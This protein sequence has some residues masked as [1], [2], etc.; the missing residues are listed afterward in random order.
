MKERTDKLDFIKAEN[1]YS[2][3]SIVKRM[4]TSHTLGENIY[5]TQSL[6]RHWHSKQRTLNI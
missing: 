6:K 2:V 5:K 3:K 1:F 4:K